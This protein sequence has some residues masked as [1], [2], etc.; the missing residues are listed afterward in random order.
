DPTGATTQPVSVASLPLPTGA[1]LD[2]SVQALV[3][4][5][6]FDTK[7]GPLTE[8]AP[9]T[10]TASSGLNGRLQ[11]IAQRLTSLMALVPAALT[12]S[13]NFKVAIQEATATVPVSGAFWQ[14]TQ[15]IS[16]ADGSDTTLG[17]KADAKNSATD[18]TAITAMAVWKQISASVQAI[19]TSIAGTLTVAT[20]AVTQSGTWNIGSI[21]TLPALPAGTNSIG[22]VQ[23]GNTANTTPIL[24]TITPGTAGGWTP[25]LNNG[26]STTVATVKG[27][28][29]TLG[30]YY[31]YNPNSSVAYVQIF[32]ISGTVTLGTSTPKLSLGI[33]AT[34]GANVEFAN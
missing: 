31:I 2:A 12:G 11:R 7:I 5:S 10:D 17:S 4:Q 22:T 3:S 25:S 34:S 6:D 23:I 33:P 26:L 19:A 18:T 20:H 27:S 9:T 1:A 21:T 24:A 14:S 29:G 16:I 15:P 28:A 32:D 13:G 30:G 8:T